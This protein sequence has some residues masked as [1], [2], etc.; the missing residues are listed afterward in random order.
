MKDHLLFLQVYL[1]CY[2]VNGAADI[3]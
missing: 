1:G 3:I 2:V